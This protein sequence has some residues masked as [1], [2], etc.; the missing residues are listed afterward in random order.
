MQVLNEGMRFTIRDGSKTLGY[1]IVTKLNE[2]IDLEKYGKE[3][4]KLK[5]QRLAV[6]AEAG[7]Q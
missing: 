5:K 3:R 6:A 7:L 2:D 1:G 4:K